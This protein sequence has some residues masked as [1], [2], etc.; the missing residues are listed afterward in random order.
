MFCRVGPCSRPV[1]TAAFRR[2][3]LRASA[4]VLAAALASPYLFEYDLPFL[5]FPTLWLVIQGLE[6]GFRPYEKLGLTLLYFAPY[7]TRGSVPS[8]SI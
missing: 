5:V 2:R 1:R 8:A 4:A 3:C 6:R 7:A